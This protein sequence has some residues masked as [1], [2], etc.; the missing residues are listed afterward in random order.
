MGEAV[1]ALDE[2]GKEGEIGRHAHI[3]S[4]S[5]PALNEVG[6]EGGVG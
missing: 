5:S 3:V 2:V 4:P 1:P 6:K